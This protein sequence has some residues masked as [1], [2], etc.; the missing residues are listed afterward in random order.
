M[1]SKAAMRPSKA[2]ASTGHSS[3]TTTDHAAIRK[4]AE[5]RGAPRLPSEEPNTV[6]RPRAFSGSISGQGRETPPRRM[7]RFLRQVRG[8]QPDV[9]LSGQDLVRKNE[10]VP[11]VHSPALGPRTPSRPDTPQAFSKGPPACIG[12]R[13]AVSLRPSFKKITLRWNRYTTREVL[14]I[15][16]VYRLINDA[17]W[18]SPGH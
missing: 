10:P 8:K 3:K 18:M 16:E 5:K 11:Q 12:I 4:W 9:P 1:V 14:L 13:E 7:G 2:K 15:A 6:R 17:R